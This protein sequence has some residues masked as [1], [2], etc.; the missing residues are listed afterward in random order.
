MPESK[1]TLLQVL[2]VAVLCAFGVSALALQLQ[3]S[4]ILWV[5]GAGVL[6]ACQSDFRNHV[7]LLYVSLF[8][9]SLSPVGTD[10]H[11]EPILRF[12]VMLSLV[13][14][15][16]W[17]V[18]R[19]LLKTNVVEFR[20]NWRRRWTTAQVSYVFVAFA[21]SYLLFPWYLKDT[22]APGFLRPP[23]YPNWMVELE[24]GALGRLFL[25]TNGLGIWDELFFVNVVFAVLRRYFTFWQANLFQA[26]LFTAFLFDLG[27]TGWG[28]LIIYPFALLQGLV[29]EKTQSLFYVIVIHL[30]VDLVLYFALIQ[31]HFPEAVPIFPY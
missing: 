30:T 12:S 3:F 11:W 23:A 24:P 28:P 25:G 16:P 22:S 5:A 6:C 17:A 31:A 10:I 27:F 14:L 13:L 8:I 15:I 29:Y 9:L 19:F 2:A 26:V 20:F 18:S 4:W 1:P 21:L 7:G